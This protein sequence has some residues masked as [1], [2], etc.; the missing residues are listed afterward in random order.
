M[1]AL[2]QFDA[3]I[4]SAINGWHAAYFD[5]FMWLVTKI[6][7]WIPMILMLLYLLYFKK[8]W[9]K[10]VAVV[11]AIALVILIADQVSASIIKPLVERARPS[12][13]ESLQSTIHIVNGYRGGPFGFVSSH[14]AN[15][16]GIALL[17]AM[18]FKNRLFTWTM[19]VWATLMCY[20]RIYL[21]VHY[22][23][24]IVRG[25]ILGFLAAWLVYRIFVWF[26]K[27][28]PEWGSVSF[29]YNESRQLIYAAVINITILA[30]WA[31]FITTT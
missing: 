11:L 29:S 3:G 26:G 5:S 9:R 8:G 7:T 20:S 30:V 14:A 22:P 10:T 19:V 16:F 27:K 6:A 18:I 4:F 23:G 21:G 28:H 13:N 25:A 12:H 2:Q 24:D 1:D 31:V 15:C 17:L